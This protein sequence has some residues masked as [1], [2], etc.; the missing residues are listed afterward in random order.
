MEVMIGKT[1]LSLI[2]GDITQ[3]NTEAIV[4]AANTSLLG[5][6]GVDGAIHRVGGP[7]ILKE[8]KEIRAR[9]GGCHTGKAV[10]T[11][12]GKLKARWVIHTVGP[13][14]SGKNNDDN[15][16]RNAYCNSLTLAEE[17]GIR[18]IAFPSISTGA[19]LFPLERAARVAL[20]ALNDFL[21]KPR[22]LEEVRFVLFSKE[23]LKVYEDCWKEISGLKS[24]LAYE[25]K[26]VKLRLDELLLPDGRKSIHETVEHRGAACAIPL[27]PDGRVVLV[28]QFRQATG[29]IIYEIPAGRL[30]EGEE[31]QDCIKRELMEEI[32]YRAGKLELLLFYYVSPGFSNEMIHIFRATGL[33]EEKQDTGEHE[34]LEIVTLSLPEAFKMIKEGKIRDGKTIL[35]LLL[36]RSKL[37]TANFWN[38]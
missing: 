7:Q 20:T 18:A 21:K 22:C 11:G 25:G 16:L 10:I 35:G 27:L 28:K 9:Q 4:N 33:K 23:I 38:Q 30:E 15:L 29:E 12:G 13:I 14:W 2:Q 26:V 1:K 19:Y 36:I 32:G 8:C 3:Q 17:K 24:K 31:P 6:G 34:L 5:G 37:S